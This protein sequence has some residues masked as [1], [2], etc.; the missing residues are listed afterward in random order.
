MKQPFSL[1]R[2]PRV[3]PAAGWPAHESPAQSL[4]IIRTILHGSEQYAV[5]LRKNG[6][7]IGAIGLKTRATCPYLQADN[8]YAAGYWV[9]VPYWGQGFAPEA[10]ARLI[11]HAREDLGARAI[12]ADHFLSNT[13]SH[14][15][16]EKCGLS[17]VGTA[18][19]DAMG[20][21]GSHEILIMHRDVSS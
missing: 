1:A 18:A 16:M 7:L 6:V 2:D 13:R 8:D 17:P 20:P 11:E 15:V 21:D 5:T 12:W 10:L 9:G 14:R 4:D 3:G 19:S